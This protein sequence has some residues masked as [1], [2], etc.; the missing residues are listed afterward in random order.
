MNNASSVEKFSWFLDILKQL[1]AYSSALAALS[2]LFG[3]SYFQGY[4]ETLGIDISFIRLSLFD[5]LESGWLFLWATGL[6]LVI[7]VQ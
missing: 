6:L 1:L 2:Y 3:R 4:F 7:I 5:Y